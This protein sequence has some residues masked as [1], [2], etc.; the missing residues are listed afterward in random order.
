MLIWACVGECVSMPVWHTFL[1]M[2]GCVSECMYWTL[3]CLDCR[4]EQV[5]I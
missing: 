4:C 1:S 5:Y 2:R 3:V